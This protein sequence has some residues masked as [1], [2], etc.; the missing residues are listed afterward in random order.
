M[1]A[2][3]R[4]ESDGSTCQHCGTEL[5]TA[6]I[7]FEHTPDVTESMDRERAELQPGEM[8]QVAYCPTPDGPA[9]TAGETGAQV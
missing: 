2:H 6:T 4:P 8:A 5:A 1:T 3:T 9:G 7:D